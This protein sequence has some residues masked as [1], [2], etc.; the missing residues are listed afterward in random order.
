MTEQAGTSQSSVNL[1]LCPKCKKP[2]TIFRFAEEPTYDPWIKE[3]FL[4]LY[5]ITHLPDGPVKYFISP[6]EKIWYPRNKPPPG[7]Y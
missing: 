7:N 2:M 1:G 5:C 4:Y 3:R 6:Q